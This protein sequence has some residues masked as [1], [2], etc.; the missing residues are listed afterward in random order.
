MLRHPG[1]YNVG[2][3]VGHRGI[4]KC[5][6]E[7]LKLPILALAAG[8]DPGKQMETLVGKDQA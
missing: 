7:Y 8:G 2:D 1:A 3:V 6:R 4:S 5:D